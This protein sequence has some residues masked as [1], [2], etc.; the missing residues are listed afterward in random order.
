[1]S[2]I[3]FSFDDVLTSCVA[4]DLEQ[5][6]VVMLLGE[7]GIGKSAWAASLAAT[8]D[9]SAF[10][11]IACNQLANKEDLTG[12]RLVQVQKAD[13]SLDYEQRFYPHAVIR[14]TV[15]AAEAD[16][17]RPVL[18]FL[19]EINR[20]TSDVTSELLSIPTARE[21]A[22]TRLPS[23][24][25]VVAAGNDHGNVVALDEASISRF[26][27]YRV[28][29]DIDTFLKFNADLNPHVQRVLE[30]NPKLLFCKA[31]QVALP[32]KG[33][34]ESDD[35]YVDDLIDED[36]GMQ[37]IT[38]PRTITA[39][40]RILN[41]LG[42][43]NIAQLLHDVRA[44]DTGTDTGNG[45]SMLQGLIEAHTGET[46]FS[47]LLVQ[48]IADSFANASKS[49]NQLAIK[50]PTGFDDLVACRDLTQLQ[51][52]VAMLSDRQRSE[53]LVWACVDPEPREAVTRA[54]TSAI[55]RLEPADISKLMSAATTAGALNARNFQAFTSTDTP[56]VETFRQMLGL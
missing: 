36:D 31:T 23:N 33:D 12:A 30:K 55:T 28:G 8:I 35:E 32:T 2:K 25:L 14:R 16:P 50:K 47:A 49:G 18:L 38:T 39:V 34:D 52:S 22:G 11:T 20:T 9:A 48:E 54:L 45:A 40:S 26:S 7:P 46:L 15:E 37:Q 51:Q 42:E 6:N 5:G 27:L 13:G 4:A 53:M 56:F 29:P 19:D 10:F 41:A 24:V 3:R 17:S 44:T 21:I 1:M 43:D